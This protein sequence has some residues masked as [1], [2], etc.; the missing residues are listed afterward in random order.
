[1]KKGKDIVVYKYSVQ[2][3]IFLI[4]ETNYL[5]IFSENNNN[6]FCGVVIFF[7]SIIFIEI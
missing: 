4:K 6:S 5:I 3:N 1:V 2:G 7:V